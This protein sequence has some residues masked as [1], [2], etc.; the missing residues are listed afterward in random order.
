M[1][2][3]PGVETGVNSPQSSPFPLN[4]LIY[5][6]TSYSI[7]T[8]YLTHTQRTSRRG[9]NSLT[10]RLL[11]KRQTDAENE[12]VSIQQHGIKRLVKSLTD[13]SPSYNV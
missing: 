1:S 11:C 8:I 2:L 13:Y 10:K 9:P 12:V 6:L 4:D 3:D 7:I 5:E